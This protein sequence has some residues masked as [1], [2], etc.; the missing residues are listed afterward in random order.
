LLEED[1]DKMSAGLE[2]IGH[3][4]MR[5][6]IDGYVDTVVAQLTGLSKDGSPIVN[7]STSSDSPSAKSRLPVFKI[8]S[9]IK[10]IMQ[11]SIIY[12]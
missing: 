12:T 6:Q 2:E 1:E 11:V 4:L 3:K 8:L 10:L 7:P 5:D 9:I